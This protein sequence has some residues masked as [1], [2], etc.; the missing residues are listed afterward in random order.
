[1]GEWLNSLKI[2]CVICGE[3]EPVCLDFHHINPDEK[4]FTIGK[5]RNKSKE[6]LLLEISKCICLCANCHRKLH[7][8]LINLNKYLDKSSPCT[9]EESVTE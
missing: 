5:H 4:K 1:M 9:T 6:N 2:K 8:G 3:S 7:A